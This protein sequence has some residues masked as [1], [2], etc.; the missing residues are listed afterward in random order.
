MRDLTVVIVTEET[1][2]LPLFT[3]PS[4]LCQFHDMEWVAVGKLSLFDVPIGSLQHIVGIGNHSVLNFCML[5]FLI[6]FFRDF[7]CMLQY[8]SACGYLK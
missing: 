6:I 5:A 1:C 3:R 8:L 2:R 7:V 4:Y